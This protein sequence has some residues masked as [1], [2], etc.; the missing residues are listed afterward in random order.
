MCL[1]A[2]ATA[3]KTPKLSFWFIVITLTLLAGF[4]HESV[5]IDV[6]LGRAFASLARFGIAVGHGRSKASRSDGSGD[7]RSKNLHFCSF[8]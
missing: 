4:R 6:R 2:A 5:G 3:K 1:M 7:S 8:C